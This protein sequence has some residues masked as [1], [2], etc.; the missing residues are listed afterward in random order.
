MRF[1]QPDRRGWGAD[2]VGRGELIKTRFFNYF[3]SG[4]IKHD[5]PS[6]PGGLRSPFSFLSVPR[7]LHGQ[8]WLNAKQQDNTMG[9]KS[10]HQVTRG[11]RYIHPNTP[12]PQKSRHPT[13]NPTRRTPFA[14]VRKNTH[15]AGEFSLFL[16]KWRSRLAGGA[17]RS[18]PVR[19][20]VG[21]NFGGCF[22]RHT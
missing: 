12:A 18:R 3:K 4:F 1:G 11:P 19:A 8:R 16:L 22:P 14:A 15:R 6:C 2:V 7:G 10:S 13:S 5:T 20:G 21:K 9:L 17:S